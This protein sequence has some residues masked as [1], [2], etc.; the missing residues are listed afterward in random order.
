[1]TSLRN[2]EQKVKNLGEVA[3]LA[4]CLRYKTVPAWRIA[5]EIGYSLRTVRSHIS[6]LKEIGV[7]RVKHNF[8]KVPT[9][10]PGKDPPSFTPYDESIHRRR[11][12]QPNTY[13]LPERSI[14]PLNPNSLIE[15]QEILREVIAH[16]GLRGAKDRDFLLLRILTLL[17][18]IA[19]RLRAE[20]MELLLAGFKYLRRKRGGLKSAVGVLEETKEFFQK[21]SRGG[22]RNPLGYFI[23]TIA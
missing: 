20:A 5:R 23:W 19:A 12:Q 8:Q 6:H 13:R 18:E 2:P 11:W 3:T 22:I 21:R 15:I 7:L 1:M 9:Y 4:C 16:N 10:S 17:G 14:S